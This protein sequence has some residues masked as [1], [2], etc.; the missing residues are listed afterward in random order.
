VSAPILEGGCLCGAVRYRASGEASSPTLCHCATCRRAA[1]SPMVAWITVPARSFAFTRGKPVEFH[2]SDAVTRSF[3]GAC[4]TPLTYQ[5]AKAPGEIDVTVASAD[6]PGLYAPRDHIWTGQGIGWMQGDDGRPRHRETRERSLEAKIQMFGERVPGRSYTVRR[7]AYAVIFGAEGR[8]AT[9]K[10][11]RGHF[12]PGG[13]IER[14]ES[15]ESGLVREVREECA[16]E[17]ALARCIGEAVQWFRASRGYF[18]GHHVFFAGRF[19]SEP[20]G[21]GEHEL[22]WL[23]PARAVELFFHA[24][25][26]WAI[27]LPRG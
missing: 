7:A 18:E 1:G 24:S 9:V 19:A 8:V 5:N 22:V 10:T 23:E 21:R 16:R 11:R 17:I 26:A 3:C 12:L 15:D 25:H 13:G 6:D 4:G 2:S 20:S 27:G 14:G